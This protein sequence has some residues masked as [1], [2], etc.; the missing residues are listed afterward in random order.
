MN[1]IL[2]LIQTNSAFNN[3]FSASINASL[4]AFNAVPNAA[5][6]VATSTAQGSPITLT[7]AN[8]AVTTIN[9]AITTIN[10]FR[11]HSDKL[12][13]INIG[14]GTTLGSIAS[15]MA[16]QRTISENSL[17]S[18]FLS[19]FGAI[20]NAA[21]LIAKIGQLVLETER[22]LGN[23]G[24]YLNNYIQIV[25][26][27]ANDLTDQIAADLEAFAAAQ[28]FMNQSA[29]ASA[30]NSLIDDECFSQVLGAIATQP[31]KNKVY[32]LQQAGRKKKTEIKS[33]VS[34]AI[35]DTTG[36]VPSG[37]KV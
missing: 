14:E 4:T 20:V 6:L 29:I 8:S 35:A 1:D 23:I 12:S 5:G 2:Q 24:G 15:V 32:E 7:Q 21:A 9:Q 36:K 27:I 13:G 34:K 17:C 18:T 25:N 28:T 26:Q 19:A 30:I 11:T 31:L 33:R 22:F 37:I 10:Q 3:P 16:S